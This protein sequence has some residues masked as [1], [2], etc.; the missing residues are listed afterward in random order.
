[1][2]DWESHKQL[3]LQAR[4][5]KALYRIGD[6]LQ[7]MFYMYREV[8]FDMAVPSIE[9]KD[10]IW[11]IPTGTREEVPCVPYMPM[12]FPF[13]NHLVKTKEDKQG[14]LTLMASPDSV[15]IMHDMVN[16]LMA[17]KHD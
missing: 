13:P 7:A 17:G 3:C 12:L 14:L 8:A 9:E 6:L 11:R 16:Y 5:R 1:M 2:T 4:A 15:G 10:G